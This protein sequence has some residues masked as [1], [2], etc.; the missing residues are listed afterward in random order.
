M[1]QAGTWGS[2]ATK[3]SYRCLA[4][5]LDVAGCLTIMSMTSSPL[6]RPVSPM[7]VFSP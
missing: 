7:N 4:M 3:K 1:A 2:S 6:K 5:N